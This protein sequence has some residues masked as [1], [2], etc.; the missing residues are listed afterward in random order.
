MRYTPK[1]R[2]EARGRIILA[3]AGAIRAQGLTE[4]SVSDIM[5]RAGLTHGAFYHHFTD[6]D[7]LVAEAVAAAA[8]QTSE[9]VFAD[10]ADRASMVGTYCS[11]SHADAS[12]EGCVLAA[13]GTEA[14]HSDSKSVRAVFATSARGFLRHVARILRS[15]GRGRDTS[16]PDSLHTVD[17]ID[18]EALSLAS[19][20]VG[21]VILARLV[22]DR[23]LAGR[24]LEVA[25]R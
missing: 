9:R 8:A 22:D 7:A 5:A 10:D 15:A 11:L 12:G 13:L 14:A 21:A 2:V 24:I 18:D 25:R 16:N 1:H 4:P 6:R 23:R 20:M 19:R 17:E 3:A